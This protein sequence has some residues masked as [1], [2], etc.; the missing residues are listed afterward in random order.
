MID[1]MVIKVK[2]IIPN[3]PTAAGTRPTSE[4]ACGYREDKAS[5]KKIYILDKHK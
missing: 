5:N 1:G 4:E 3:D 2:R